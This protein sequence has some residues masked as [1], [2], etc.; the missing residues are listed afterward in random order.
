VLGISPE[1]AAVTGLE[2]FPERLA[3]VEAKLEP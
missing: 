1:I 2:V 3:G